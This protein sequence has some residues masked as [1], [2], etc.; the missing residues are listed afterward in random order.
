MHLGLWFVKGEEMISQKIADNG[1]EFFLDGVK[2]GTAIRREGTEDWFTEVRPGEVLWVRTTA[3]PADT[4]ELRFETAY[5]PSW[6]MIPAVSY[7][8]NRCAIQD[9]NDVRESGL[10]A[11]KDEAEREKT[12]GSAGQQPE[13]GDAAEQPAQTREKREFPTFFAGDRDPED[14]TS[15]RMLWHRSSVPGATYSEGRRDGTAAG[16]HAAD[17]NTDSG[18]AAV[19]N[20]TAE[21]S[22]EYDSVSM[23]LPEWEEGGAMSLFSE[24]GKAVHCLLW[25]EQ[26]SFLKYFDHPEAHL[27]KMVPRR[28]FGAVLI[29]GREAEVHA[30]FRAMLSSAWRRNDYGRPNCRTDA[31]LWD[32]GISYAKKLY[33]REPDGFCGFSIGFT[34]DGKWVKRPDQKYEIGWCGQNASLANSLLAQAEKREDPEAVQMG[35]SVLDAWYA[36]RR[37]HGLIPTHYDG[38]LYTNGFAKTVDACNLGTAAMQYNEA[39]GRAFRLGFPRPEYADLSRAICDFALRV[40]NAEG[41][42]GKSWL[43]EDLSP[44]VQEGTT[45]AF[46]SMALADE[47]EVTGEDCYLE[48]AEKSMQYYNRELAQNGYTT[49]GALDIFSIDKESSI[50]LLKGNLMLY[51]LTQKPEYLEGAVRAAW[52]LSTWQWHYTRKYPAGSMLNDM[53]YDTFGG[54]AVSIHSGMDPF[55]LSYVNALRQL[56]GYTGDSAWEKRADAIWHHGMQCISDGDLVLGGKNPRPRGSQDESVQLTLS[57]WKENEP[58]E[59][60]VAWPTAFRLEALR[61]PAFQS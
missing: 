35:L 30:G 49:A 3:S 61:N 18:N 25:P 4:M 37:P 13:S 53:R 31:E 52:Y 47:A 59:W 17:R 12:S 46:L 56:A 60:L 27:K 16:N 54:T 19:G 5:T 15:W 10:R 24:N 11:E 39:A 51:A 41:R 28:M 48:G 33:T 44:A 21:A 32:L 7:H 40:M 23:F 29:F 58:S 57:N 9:Y 8:G 50:P 20:S 26:D 14:G 2:M 38:N 45:G 1:T 55:A 36:A 34:W 6:T 42:I 22:G 43:E